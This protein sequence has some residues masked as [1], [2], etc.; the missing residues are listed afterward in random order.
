MRN[1][2][3]TGVGLVTP[4]GLV[5]GE[6]VSAIEAGRTVAAAPAGFDPSPFACRVC[7]P[8]PQFDI[9]R[10]VPDPKTVRLMNRDALLAAAAARRAVQDAD[11]LV[12]RDYAAQRVGLFGATGMAGIPL[13]EVKP[14]IRHSADA[15]GRFDPQR[16]GSAALRRV[17]PVLTFKILA[18]MPMCFVSIFE[19]IRG[20]NG[21]YTPWEGQG[22][23]AV[24]AGIEAI[25]AGR[26][27]CA[28]VGGCD[29]KTHLLGFFALQQQGLFDSWTRDGSG[30]VPAEGAVFLALEDEQRA[31]RR[32][33]RVRARLHGWSIRTVRPGRERVK[34]YADVLASLEAAGAGA[35]LSAGD[36][37]CQ[38]VRDEDLALQ[39]A[40]LQDCGRTYPKRS[41]G[42][43]F[44][45]SAALQVAVAALVAEQSGSG[46]R[47]L[48][49]CFGH[50]SQQAAFV[51]EA[52]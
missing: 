15:A 5:P 49:N 47:V 36:G 31:R 10:Y 27:D 43:M 17:R 34:T 19:S 20:V 52:A 23:Q 29:V 14:L 44:A 13:E 25:G 46:T 18:N 7:A 33:A 28:L 35:I 21:I 51:L 26:A 40:G 38:I 41:A 4:L 39:A 8:V 37:D 2:V 9:Q 48:A 1:V 22:A 30:P 42:N 6:V 45:A 11:L 16:F 12:E 32:G 50:G 24:I 3:V